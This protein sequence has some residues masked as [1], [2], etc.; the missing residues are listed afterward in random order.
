MD[1][2]KDLPA[3]KRLPHCDYPGAADVGSRGLQPLPD[4][5]PVMTLAAA[6]QYRSSKFQIATADT[7]CTEKLLQMAGVIARSFA[8]NDPM[9]RQLRP[10]KE[11]PA[12]V[13]GTKHKDPFG[14]DDFGGWTKENIL[15]WFIRLFIFTEPFSPLDAIVQ[16]ES[17]LMQSLAALNGVGEVIGGA[18][19]ISL[20]LSKAG[21]AI[22]DNDP[23]ISAVFS[24]FE[25]GAQ[26][27][28][29]QVNLSINALCK[30]YP[31]FLGALKAGKVADLNMVAR[32]PL[33]PSEDTFELVAATV[34]HLQQLRFEFLIISAGNQWTG[35]A[36]RVLGGVKVH[37]ASYRDLKRVC[38]SN[39]AVAD[40]PSSAD[41]FI[42][43][44]DSGCMFY[45]IRLK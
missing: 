12:E 4:E 27:L 16:N 39:E 14:D 45:V 2:N 23:F 29:S 22:R 20:D 18:L 5:L 35:A 9:I 15:F 30:K 10:P 1:I 21:R 13:S 42:S 26:F 32:S 33:L 44:K 25:P 28:T 11:C 34:V 31:A 40:K 43:G 8:V 36:C 24:F 19:N 3:G 6:Q 17:A 41:G 7:L 37:F 38:E